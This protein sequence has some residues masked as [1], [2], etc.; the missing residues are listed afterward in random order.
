[1]KETFFNNDSRKVRV[2]G[3]LTR[4]QKKRKLLDDLISDGLE[5][6][7]HDTNLKELLIQEFFR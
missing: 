7:S 3:D 4:N 1:M 6:K 5:E 2:I